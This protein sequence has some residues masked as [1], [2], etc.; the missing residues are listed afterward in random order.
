MGAILARLLQASPAERFQSAREVRQA[1]LTA[2]A[3][4]PAGLARPA[5]AAL[6]VTRHVELSPS[7]PRP[8]T[9]RTKRL[10]NEVAPS[11]LQLMDGSAKQ[12]DEPGFIDGLLLVFFSIITAG[13]LPLTFMSMARAKRRRLRRFLR[14]GL[15]ADAEIKSIQIEKMA[16]DST[17]ARVSYEFE[18]D[19]L[20]HRDTDQILPVIAGRWRPGDQIQ[21]L[22][23]PE[24]NYDSAIISTA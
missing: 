6:K 23:L 13:I 14:D 7:L 18:A 2:P 24:Y 21:V 9:G 3:A 15:P 19:G 1:L 20:L 16:F 11:T 12:T 17:I 10:L 8:I 22:Y 4:T 5:Y